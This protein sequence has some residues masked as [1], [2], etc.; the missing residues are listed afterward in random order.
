[1]KI[2]LE[3][4]LEEKQNKKAKLRLEGEKHHE[5]PIKEKLEREAQTPRRVSTVTS[6]QSSCTIFTSKHILAEAPTEF[7]LKPAAHGAGRSQSEESLL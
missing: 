4:S 6:S 1:M 5:D 2:V 3:K 7:L